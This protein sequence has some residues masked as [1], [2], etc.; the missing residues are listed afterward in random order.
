M[1]ALQCPNCGLEAEAT[2]T[3]CRRCGHSLAA[4][5]QPPLPSYPT[6]AY[7]EALAQSPPTPT[8]DVWDAR[9]LGQ[10]H[11]RSRRTALG[12]RV[13]LQL[14]TP[15]LLLGLVVVVLLYTGPTLLAKLRSSIASP[16]PAPTATVLTT[17]NGEVI[18]YRAALNTATIG[19]ERQ[20]GCTF[21]ADGLHVTDG[22][23]CF[24]PLAPGLTDVHV[25]VTLKQVAG[26]DDSWNG[27][28][29]RTS[30]SNDAHQL[31]YFFGFESNGHWGFHKCTATSSVCT[32]L[33]VKPNNTALHTR[34]N[35]EN[36]LDVSARGS[37]FAFAIN[38]VPVGAYDDATYTGGMVG[39]DGDEGSETVYSNLTISRPK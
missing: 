29:I 19:W 7:Y 5:P 28:A 2:D 34:L 27:V 10:Q 20:D 26:R 11:P 22:F 21:R 3:V 25:V 23:V 6:P 24:A 32:P 31:N 1:P 8:A 14:V 36:T 33:V 15:L 13:L 16:T 12:G 37:H 4:A 35:A 17:A 18:L 39:M 9:S 38:G 30:Y